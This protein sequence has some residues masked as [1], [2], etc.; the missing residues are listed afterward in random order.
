MYHTFVI[1]KFIGIYSIND[2]IDWL[3]TWQLAL[4]DLLVNL[5]ATSSR[6]VNQ[7]YWC[8]ADPILSNLQDLSST[9]FFDL[10]RRFSCTECTQLH[11]DRY[12]HIVIFDCWTD[13]LTTLFV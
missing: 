2:S 5:T 8:V 3:I 13:F 11:I 9:K 12:C 1:G 6:L 7:L 4:V 10:T